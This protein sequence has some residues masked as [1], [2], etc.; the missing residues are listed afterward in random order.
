[1]RNCCF[2]QSYLNVEKRIEHTIVAKLD[3]FVEMKTRQINNSVSNWTN[4]ATS[5]VKSSQINN[6]ID[7]N[8]GEIIEQI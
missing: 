5:Q 4:R 2:P 7:Q 6:R 8:E 1:M 3:G